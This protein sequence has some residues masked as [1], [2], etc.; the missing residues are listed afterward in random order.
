MYY[1]IHFITCKNSQ[2]NKTLFY[3]RLTTSAHDKKSVYNEPDSHKFRWQSG[4]DAYIF[5][6]YV[7]DFFTLP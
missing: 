2:K 6:F 7:S 3:F 1:I 5:Y 4:K